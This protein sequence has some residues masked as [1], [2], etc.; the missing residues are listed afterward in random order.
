MYVL[1]S[2]LYIHRGICTQVRTVFLSSLQ[3]FGA[4][5]RVCSTPERTHVHTYQHANTRTDKQTVKTMVIHT[6]MRT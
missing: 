2:L 3:L 1:L 5:A 6:D 4:P